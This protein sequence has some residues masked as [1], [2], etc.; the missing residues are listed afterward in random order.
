M[1]SITMCDVCKN[2]VKHEESKYVE[3]YSVRKDN[4][5]GTK[6]HSLEV[7]PACYEKLCAVLK[8]EVKK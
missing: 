2:V 8:I 7:C 4:C 5:T 3:V 1:A 6:I